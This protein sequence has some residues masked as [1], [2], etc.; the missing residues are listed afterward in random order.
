VRKQLI[1]NKIMEIL[2]DYDSSDWDEN[3]LEEIRER[4]RKILGEELNKK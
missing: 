2:E 4:I 1:E 3:V